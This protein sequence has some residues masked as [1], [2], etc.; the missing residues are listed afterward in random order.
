MRWVAVALVA[1]TI[2]CSRPPQT[3]L[4]GSILLDGQ[5]LP[6][7]TMV[8][9]PLSGIGRVSYADAD[10]AGRFRVEVTPTPLSVMVLTADPGSKVEHPSVPGEFIE[11]RRSL[12][13]RRY[14]SQKLTPLRANPVA[15]E[16]TNCELSLVSMEKN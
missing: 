13:P 15:G 7:A 5:P 11:D 9:F 10:A 12:V 1:F 3:I 4:T 16:T 6:H 8:F 14:A 2:G